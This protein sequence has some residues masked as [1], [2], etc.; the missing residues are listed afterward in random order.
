MKAYGF[1]IG[2]RGSGFGYDRKISPGDNCEKGTH[3][4]VGRMNALR[5]KKKTARRAGKNNIKET[6]ND[7]EGEQK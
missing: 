2:G 7:M 6:I 4:S 5:H 1:M 3:R